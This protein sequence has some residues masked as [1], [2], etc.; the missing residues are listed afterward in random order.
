M[1]SSFVRAS[2]PISD[3]PTSMMNALSSRICRAES[4]GGDFGLQVAQT[5]IA[6]DDTLLEIGLGVECMCIFFD[7]EERILIRLWV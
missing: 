1:I 7:I 5:K 4:G 6:A 3:A 2:V